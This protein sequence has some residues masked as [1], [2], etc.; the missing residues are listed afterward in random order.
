MLT[1][2][3][4]RYSFMCI[5]E[6]D[7]STIPTYAVWWELMNP[8]IAAISVAL[9]ASG[10][11]GYDSYCPKAK[12]PAHGY[13]VKGSLDYYEVGSVVEYACDDG[14]KLLGKSSLTCVKKEYIKVWDY[15]LPV[16]K[17]SK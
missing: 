3:D 16:C 8:I 9:F 7:Q 2:I 17:K 6:S 15:D 4:A 11:F 12:V 5:K 13:I 10:V 1:W 14:Y